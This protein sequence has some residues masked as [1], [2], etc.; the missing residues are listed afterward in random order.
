MTELDLRYLAAASEG[1]LE[2]HA[3]WIGS[4]QERML[5]V[6]LRDRGRDN[7]IT[8]VAFVRVSEVGAAT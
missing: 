2:S 5:S 1:P 8:T 6:E 4:R 3:T 7:R